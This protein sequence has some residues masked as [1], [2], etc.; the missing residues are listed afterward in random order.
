VAR[1]QRKG[2]VAI[3]C[4]GSPYN[5]PEFWLLRASPGRNGCFA[6]LGPGGWGRACDL[7]QSAQLRGPT[8]EYLEKV[9]SQ[10]LSLRQKNIKT[11]GNRSI[12]ILYPHLN[13]PRDIKH[14]S[15]P[16]KALRNTTGIKMRRRLYERPLSHVRRRSRLC[17]ADRSRRNCSSCPH[18]CRSGALAA[19]G[20]ARWRTG[21][22]PGRR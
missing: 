8:M 10:F 6:A 18:G 7:T 15:Q 13:P 1:G 22:S 11:P 21:S 16:S 4:W 19:L 9:R 12:S 20:E 3:A 5:Q 14:G 2:A 17:V